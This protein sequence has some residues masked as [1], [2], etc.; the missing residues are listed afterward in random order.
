[1]YLDHNWIGVDVWFKARKKSLQED[2]NLIGLRNMNS[3]YMELLAVQ[4]SRRMTNPL[5]TLVRQIAKDVVEA[6]TPKAEEPPVEEILE[7]SGQ[8]TQE[9]TEG[10]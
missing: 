7:T 8:E 6:L 1:M 5:A 9:T 10:G 3:L 4:K 2:G